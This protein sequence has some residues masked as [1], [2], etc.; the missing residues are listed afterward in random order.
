MAHSEQSATGRKRHW[1]FV[2]WVA[3]SIVVAAWIA[4][5]APV[6]EYFHGAHWMVAYAVP[7]LMAFFLLVGL[8]WLV[9][10]ATARRHGAPRN[11]PPR[12]GNG[13]RL[14]VHQTRRR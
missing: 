1:A 7:A 12:P 3:A 9:Y 4:V 5:S 13:P 10:L 14:D 2:A 6:T 8:G 11:R